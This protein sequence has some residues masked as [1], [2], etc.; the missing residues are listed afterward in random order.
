MSFGPRIRDEVVL[1]TACGCEKII[2][3]PD[4]TRIHQQ[5]I[6]V[7]SPYYPR[8]GDGGGLPSAADQTYM[9][10]RFVFDWEYDE[11]GRRI[12]QEHVEE[13]YSVNW[14]QNYEMLYNEVYGMDKGL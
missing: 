6:R 10:R 13:G 8:E 9:L 12:F 14:K 2:S 11:A 7:G 5:A 3:V 1:R 4:E